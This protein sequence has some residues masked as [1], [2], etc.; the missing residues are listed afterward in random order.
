MKRITFFLIVLATSF[1]LFAQ[2]TSEILWKIGA[3]NSDL[4]INQGDTVIW[5]WSDNLTHTVT[6]LPNSEE[7]FDSKDKIGLG[8][9]FSHTFT[10]IG[11][12]QYRCSIHPDTMFGTIHV[13]VLGIEDEENKKTSI[14]PNPVVNQLTISSPIK[15]DKIN[16]TNISGKKVLERNIHADKIN[17]DMSNYRNGMYF[18]QIESDAKKYTYRIIKK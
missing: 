6:S 8:V 14:F 15:I 4:I 5:V 7:E 16:I 13:R 17:I 10:K 3:S 12:F 18:I 2:D 11:D 1:S 9:I